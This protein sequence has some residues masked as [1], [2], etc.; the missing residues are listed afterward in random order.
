MQQVR[1][2]HRVG[3]ERLSAGECQQAMGHA[4]GTAHGL[5]AQ[6]KQCGQRIEAALL[7]A[8]TDQLQATANTGE[9][10]VEVVGNA[11]GQLADGFHLLR[12]AQVLLVFAQLAQLFF[13]PAL[14]AAQR[15][16]VTS[17]LVLAATGAQ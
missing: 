5:L 2:L 1:Q 11:T 15:Q 9:Q 16:P 6:F 14:Q 10:V 8:F 17:G 4:G 13:H 12:L 3:I 7:Q